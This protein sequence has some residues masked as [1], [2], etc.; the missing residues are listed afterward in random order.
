VFPFPQLIPAGVEVR[1]PLP[2]PIVE[3]VRVLFVEVAGVVVD[4]V[5]VAIITGGVVV[6]VVVATTTTGV[7]EEVEVATVVVA[8]VVA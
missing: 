2:V 7:V 1:V 4:S 3:T 5:V 6:G 8:T